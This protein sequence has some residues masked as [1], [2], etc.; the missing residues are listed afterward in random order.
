MKVVF[1]ERARDDIANIYDEIALHSRPAARRVEDFIRR[2]CERLGDFPHVG[3]SIDEPDVYRLPLLR[4]PYTIFYRVNNAR[5]VLEIA[6][7]I[8]GARIRN[9]KQ[10]P[11]ND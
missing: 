6:R 4:Y 10:L 2:Q 8:H 11:G 7:V 1:A 5:Q 9:L 3:T